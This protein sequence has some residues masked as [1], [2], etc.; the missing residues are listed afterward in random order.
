[1]VPG[2]SRLLSP[3]RIAVVGGGVWCANVILQCRKFGFSGE[4]IAVHPYR[5]EVEGC[6][7]VREIGALPWSP[8]AA[9]VGVNREATVT[10]VR[11]LAGLGAGGAVCF[12][13]GFAEAGAELDG[14]T[15]LQQALR[16]AAGSM[17]VLGPNCYG[18]LN[19]LDGVGLWPDQHG[20]ARVDGG[21][22]V[23]TQSSNMAINITMQ[24]RA[25]PLAYV[26]TAGNQAQLDQAV[27]GMALLSDDRV[28]ALGLHIEGVRDPLALQE[29]A[30]HAAAL[31]KPIIALK[32]GHSEEARVATLSHTA[33]LVGRA[34]GASALFA[35]LGIGEVR[36]LT[37][38]LETLKLLHCFGSLPEAS[39]ASASCSGGEASLMADT[40]LRHGIRFPPL[41]GPTRSALRTALGP[42]VALSNP[43]DY[44]TYIWG[45]VDRMAAVFAAL[46]GSGVALACVIADFPDPARCEVSAWECVVEALARVVRSG[47][48]IALAVT[49]PEGL[50]DPV[51][52]RAEAAGVPT[53]RGL[54]DLAGAIRAAARCGRPAGACLLPPRAPV[55]AAPLTE[56]AAKSALSACGLAVPRA[57]RAEGKIGLA[58]ALRQV[59]E[60]AVIKAEGIAHKT[61]RGGVVFMTDGPMAAMSA[62]VAM[63]CDSW[64]VEE[65]I[66][67]AV[68]ELLVGV[69]C[70]P[71][72]G[73]LLTLGAGGVESELRRDT[74]HLL[75]PV[76]EAEILAALDRLVLSP[77]LNGY[78]GRPAA[79]LAAIAQAVL[80]VQTYVMAEHGRL[81]EV[82]INPLICTPDRAVAVDA[83]ITLGETE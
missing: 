70:D 78:R 3:R 59:G 62:A 55:A 80:A 15:A 54:D 60:P 22:A 26:V 81:A 56:A 27:L 39:L 49:M 9:F 43:L 13:S 77:L 37:E 20:G 18:F 16:G 28:T 17:P 21:V 32:V 7:A 76:T 74:T 34:E 50:P 44:H 58:A 11:A 73:Y 63:P 24:T 69:T 14:A 52:D 8:D 53:F 4:V 67:G 10:A 30:R 40:G 48:R 71:S 64:L 38:F 57:R 1:M 33:S 19:Y 45:D 51:R 46:A 41:D 23:I 6:P 12:A 25:L 65:R 66:T 47:G 31:G 75:L 82:E 61:E 36:S 42:R 29:L 35:R 83:L 79:K 2:L 72:H 5:D 68:A